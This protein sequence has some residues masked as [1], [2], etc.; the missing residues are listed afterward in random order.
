MDMQCL[1]IKKP[2]NGEPVFDKRKMN[3]GRPKKLSI[4]DERSIIRTIPKLREE[5]GKVTSK[6]V[7]FESCVYHVNN[8]TIRNVLKREGY[9][10]L[11]ARKKGLL[12]VA[13]LKSRKKFCN[14]VLRKKLGQN[15]WNT[16]IS[17]YL[18]GKDFQYKSNPLD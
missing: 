18:E 13:D 14:K 1:F 5:L 12:H 10:Y 7:Q 6:R 4:Q 9:H 16:G 11:R 3:K 17:L 15:L 8:R 2:L